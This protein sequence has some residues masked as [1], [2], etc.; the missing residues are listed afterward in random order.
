MYRLRPFGVPLRAGILALLIAI[1]ARPGLSAAE[2]TSRYIRRLDNAST[3]IIF[4]HGVTSSGETAWRSKTSYW[5]SMLTSDSAFDGADIFVH[6][7]PT[8]FWATMSIDEL[9]EDMRV[10][11][12]GNGVTD[13][14]KL[15]FVAHSM[16]GLVVRAYLFKHRD[17]AAKTL[18][19]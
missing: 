3:V 15:I 14:K 6:S 11:F 12:N 1:L 5:P 8:S 9:A 17:I 7:Y 4:V 13:H 16:G 19:A 2:P 18:F 10:V